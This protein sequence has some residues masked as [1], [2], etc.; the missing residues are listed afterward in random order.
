MTTGTKLKLLRENKRLSQEELADAVGVTQTTIG[1]WEHGKSIKHDY[2]SKLAEAFEVSTDYLMVENYNG[3][4]IPTKMEEDSNNGFE[5][6]LKAPNNFFEEL[7]RKM[8]FLIS[9]LDEKK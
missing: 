6:I 9:R 1:N 4:V 7:N 3:M 8:D 5:F 2:I